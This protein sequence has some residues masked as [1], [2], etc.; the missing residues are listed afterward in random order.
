ML[1]IRHSYP[2]QWPHDLPPTEKWGKGINQSFNM[3][4]TLQEATNFLL[5]ELNALTVVQ[6]ATL[7]TDHQD[8]G[9]PRRVPHPV[10]NNGVVLRLKIDGSQYN[11]ACDRWVRLEHNVYALHLVLRNLR[12]MLEWGV[13]DLKRFLAG[14]LPGG[15]VASALPAGHQEGM[16][17]WRLY[18][19]LG[20]TAK[21]DDAQAV[22]RR[23]AKAVMDNEEEMLRLNLAMD[24]A[25]KTL[26]T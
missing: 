2:L 23:R 21:L 20:P 26:S 15:A 22:Y 24:A 4:M 16:E 3:A 10:V 12:V 14:F 7:C 18:L 8:L 6:E 5:E 1:T 9:N 25:S 13:G 17:E 11:I 19:G